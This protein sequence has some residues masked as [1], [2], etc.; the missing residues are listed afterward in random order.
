M[1]PELK[2]LAERAATVLVGAMAET[3]GPARQAQFAR[4]L[5]RGNTRAEQAAAATLA[6][7]AAG[8]TPR[9]QPDT[10]T[11]WRIRLQDLLRAHPGAAEDLRTLLAHD[12]AGREGRDPEPR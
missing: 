2:T 10:I 4:L 3:G 5:G 7:D 12:E 1:D 8:L 6:E 9:S 11:A